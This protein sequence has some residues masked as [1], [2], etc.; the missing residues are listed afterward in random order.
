MAIPAESMCYFNS[1]LLLIDVKKWLNLDVT[2]KVLRFIEENPD[3]LRFHDQDAL[4]AVLHDRWT[5]CILSGTPKVIFCQK[6]KNIQLFMEKNNKE[7]TRRR[8]SIIHF[9]GHVKPWTKEFQWYT[10]RYYDQYANRTA[11]R[12]VNTFNQYLSYEKLAEGLNMLNNE[13]CHGFRKISY[14]LV[15]AKTKQ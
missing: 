5:L 7:E 6:R 4:N 15:V 3:K 14:L 13:Y 8:P 11:F 9:T 10:K 1:G 2:T 12:C